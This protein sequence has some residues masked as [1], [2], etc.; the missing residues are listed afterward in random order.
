MAYA[1][2]PK[3][4]WGLLA[5]FI[6]NKRSPVYNWLY[7]K[8]GYSADLVF[9]LIEEFGLEPGKTILDPF[10][11]CGTTLLACKQRGIEAVGVDVQP[12]AVFA[13]SVKTRDYDI[14]KLKEGVRALLANRFEKPRK[15]E[16]P[17]IVKKCFSKYA[18]EDIFFFRRIINAVEDE[19]VR[20]FLLLGL[21]NAAMKVGWAWKD[22]G[23]IK[24]KKHPSPPLR[25][26]LSK[27]LGRMIKDLEKFGVQKDAMASSEKGDELANRLS[28]NNKDEAARALAASQEMSSHSPVIIVA[29]GDARKLPLAD[30]SIDAVITSPPYLNQIDYQRVYA[31]EN[32]IISGEV[33]PALRSFIG[34]APT[35]TEFLK[36]RGMPTQAQ[37]YFEDINSVLAE[38]WRVCKGGAR[39]AVVIGNAYFPPPHEPVESDVVFAELAEKLG[40]TVE[41]IFVLNQCAALRQRT[42]KVGLLRESLVL[43]RKP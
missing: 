15:A 41:K 24:V 29:M 7:Y 9:K 39:I 11:G 26:M 5:T 38:L 10:C 17:A 35:E 8:E 30:N 21:V 6:P 4:E 37:L 28:L 32:W 25:K 34:G 19:D 22:G 3:P 36:E 2:E 43:M 12:V 20:N 40:F 27:T 13:S 23:V 18:L 14:N 1:L 31:I 33:A 42:E 16:A